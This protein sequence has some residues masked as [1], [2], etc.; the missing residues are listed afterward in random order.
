[1]E[2][3][4]W[5]SFIIITFFVIYACKNN[6]DSQN[7]VENTT[8]NERRDTIKYLKDKAQFPVGAALAVNPLKNDPDYRKA[9]LESYNQ[10][11]GENAMK[12][13]VIWKSE[14]EYDWSEPDYLMDFAEENGMSVHGHT[15]IWYRRFPDWFKNANYD[16]AMFETKVKTFIE[17]VV[18]RYKGKIR[19]WD[20]ANEV[21]KD[22]G[23]HRE[24]NNPVHT[25]FTDPIGFYGRCF[26]YARGADPDVKLFYN[27]YDAVI[28]PAKRR[29]EKEMIA[30]FRNEGIPI[31]GIG[32]Q[33]HLKAD[34]DQE[35][36]Q[37]GF[38]DLANT[39]LLWH[40]SELDIRINVNKDD[41]F[42]FT[43]EA[44][45]AQAKKYETI[46]AMYEQLPEEQKFA[47]TTWGITDKYTWLTGW[48]HP[49]EYPLL[50]NRNYQKKLAYQGFLDGLK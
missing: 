30:R 26:Q 31:D 28:N 24:E 34:V 4:K 35:K 29:A 16:S 42:E 15:L 45:R 9:V 39:G 25:T 21:F 36:V 38:T 8:V 27:D 47:I 13:G 43:E 12:M 37:A 48:W 11:S 32:D 2:K 17:T 44:Q 19:S 23:S 46:V 7:T 33:F 49:K 5:I 20:V 3:L 6:D 22:D 40:I 50:Y 41:N 18:G 1:M 10:I 14:K